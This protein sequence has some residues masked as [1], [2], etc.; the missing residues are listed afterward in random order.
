M[1]SPTQQEDRIKAIWA[2]HIEVAK[3]LPALAANVS[4]AVDMIHS[5]LAAGG[6]LLIAGNGG[7]AADA[8]HIAAELTGRFL[9]ERRPMRA[10]ALHT[11]S[12]GLTAIGNDYGYEQVFARELAAH[13]RPGDV[14]LA[15]ST[16]GNSK[17]VLRA[18]DAARECKVTVI[19]LTGETGGKMRAECDLCLCVPTKSTPRMQEMH[20][21][22][23]HTI[24]ELLEEKLVGA[25]NQTDQTREDHPG[26]ENPVGS[27]NLR[28]AE[29]EQQIAVS[30][31]T[32]GSD[33]PYVFGLTMDLLSKSAVLDLIGSDELD[34][35][36]F[37][38][39]AGL[40][41]L[42]LRG[43]QRQEASVVRKMARIFKY[44][45]KLLAYAAGA[46]PKLFHILWNN[47][48]ETFDR[49]ILMLYYRALGKRIVLTAHNVNGS[50]RDSN[51]SYFNRLTL[52]VQ[53]HLAH[54]IFVHTEKMKLEL[55][56]DFFGVRESHVT[57]IP[58]GINNAIPHTN[59]TP[60]EAKQRLGIGAGEKA[61][62]FFGRI[63]PS[64]GLDYLI[65]AFRQ[66][67]VRG[68]EDYR[69][70]IAGRPD[71]CESYW[72]AIRESI[73]EEVQEG[74]ILLRPEF[75]PDDQTEIYFKGADVLVLPYRD[76]YQSG[77]LFLGHS[78][79]L[80]V[81]A[82][83][84][85][86][87]KD[88]IVEGKTGLIFQPENPP[89]LANTIERYFTSDLFA[90]LNRRRESIRKYAAERHSWD[91]VGQLTMNTYARLL[92]R[93]S[94]TGLPNNEVGKPSLD[95]QNLS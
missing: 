57:V 12:S 81:L 31:L 30:L 23:G 3:A 63:R 61:I 16:S 15:I 18:I 37:H 53:Y 84:V 62:L 22:I 74:K 72:N 32:G 24:C 51:D 92:P 55:M 11:N 93:T 7:S 47:R 6:Q 90:D 28:K 2:E 26:Y 79:G 14:L 27:R 70:I 67:L 33:K 36:Q 29:A 65:S 60:D 17:N 13:A 46:K 9:R 34:C 91:V 40:N 39:K 8:Q 50:K 68:G 38:G 48:F 19:G 59:L 75:I 10:L 64:K 21:T 1:A 44:Y 43:D 85:G 78:F 4:K 89:D 73:R 66:I 49:T 25:L 42:N 5:S 45:S 87:L 52:R 80:P 58:F 95:P 86:S 83:N 56:R 54:H 69:L 41:F 77:V 88:D 20:I 35:P 82:A 76:I 71:S 94:P